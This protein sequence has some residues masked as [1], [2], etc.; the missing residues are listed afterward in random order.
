MNLPSNAPV[1]PLH[2]RM[3]TP[4]PIRELSIPTTL[5]LSWA[6]T[7][8]PSKLSHSITCFLSS[9][10]SGPKMASF[11]MEEGKLSYKVP[12]K[13][14]VPC[15]TYYKILGHI[16]SGAPPVNVVHGG[17]GMG[18]EYLTVFADLLPIWG[19]PVILF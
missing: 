2:G 16:S 5:H 18:H 12:G 10:A 6:P 13:S 1:S 8:S 11:P 15:F 19:F 9:A 3:L 17:P 7:S 14:D 4:Y